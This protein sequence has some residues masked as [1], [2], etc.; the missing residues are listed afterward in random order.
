MYILYT[1]KTEIRFFTTYHLAPLLNEIGQAPE[2]NEE[3]YYIP[4]RAAILVHHT[5]IIEK[6]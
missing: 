5:R 2:K 4:F 1:E 3:K 6:E